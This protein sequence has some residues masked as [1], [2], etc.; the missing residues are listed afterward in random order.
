ME[1]QINAER[2]KEVWKEVVKNMW[3]A[4][5]KDEVWSEVSV[6]SRKLVDSWGEEWKGPDS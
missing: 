3:P 4:V 2:R 6:E 1:R 5:V